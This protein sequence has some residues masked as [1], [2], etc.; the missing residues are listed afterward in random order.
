MTLALI[1]VIATIVITAPYFYGKFQLA[2]NLKQGEAFLT[3]NQQNPQVHSTSSGLQ[4]LLL[5]PAKP[6][7]Q[8][9]LAKADSTISVRYKG[10][11]L[12]GTVFD[13][14]D[15]P[16]TFQLDQMIEGWKEGIPLMQIGEV[17]R[18]FIPSHLAYGNKRVGKIKPGSTLIFDI[19]LVDFY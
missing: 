5:E 7:D 11:L 12:D 4:Y 13:S 2:A 19:K 16:K 15:M 14:T 9:M 10:S 1:L 18:F 3:D 6:R 17:T 8:F